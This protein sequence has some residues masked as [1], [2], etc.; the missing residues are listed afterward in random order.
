MQDGSTI[1]ERA[2]SFT[3]P[4]EIYLSSY[5]NISYG[6]DPFIQSLVEAVFFV[7]DNGIK[8]IHNSMF[9]ACEKLKYVQIPDSV[10]SIGEFSFNS[11]TDLKH[12]AMPKNLESIG[13]RAF[14]GSSLSVVYIHDVGE[15]PDGSVVVIMQG[16][17]IFNEDT[18][19][20][21]CELDE[22]IQ[23]SKEQDQLAKEQ[24]ETESQYFR[25]NRER[26]ATL[27]MSINRHPYFPTLPQLQ[28]PHRIIRATHYPTKYVKPTIYTTKYI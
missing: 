14:L 11:T 25:N 22:F 6:R 1:G 17:T 23:R 15:L 9:Y 5:P 13:D 16:E 26:M 4:R 10:K 18:E 19:V 2:F 8:M 21:M 28:I 20:V 7:G 12:L 27:M 24:Y 3:T